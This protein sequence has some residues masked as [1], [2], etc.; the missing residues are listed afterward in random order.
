VRAEDGAVYLSL[1]VFDVKNPDDLQDF[2]IC[3]DNK[4]SIQLAA[5]LM[6]AAQKIS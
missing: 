5:D 2:H 4:I 1:R 6:E 3:L